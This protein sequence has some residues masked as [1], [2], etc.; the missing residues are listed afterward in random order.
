MLV[1]FSYKLK[2]SRAN[3]IIRNT[4]FWK[5]H[6]ILPNI[7]K[8]NVGDENFDIII[9]HDL[10]VLETGLKLA[11]HFDATIFYDSLEIYTETINQFFPNVTG[12]K[13]NIANIL[14]RFMRWAGTKAEKRMV[15]KCD[16]ITTVN[17]S[18][19][20]YFEDN[21]QLDKVHS[22]MNCP[23]NKKGVIIPLID[24]RKKYNF[25]SNDLIFL[26]QGVLNQGRGLNMLIEGFKLATEQNNNIKLIVLGEG[27]L[28]NALEQQVEQLNLTSSIK[29]TNFVPYNELFNHTI[30]ADF[31]LNFLEPFNLSKKFASP[32]KLFEYIQVGIPVLS[33]FSPENDLIYNKY[34]IGI[35]TENIPSNICEGILKLAS[36]DTNT[37][38]T[39]LSEMQKASEKYNWEHQE[40]ILIGLIH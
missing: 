10:P 13:K 8:S 11:K 24:F 2:Q 6:R 16:I 20:S 21:Y 9:C 40:E 7:I 4:F 33:S 28:R 32:N 18:L 39:Y 38:N 23:S 17:Q 3:K 36:S 29:F 37:M 15:Q 30:A 19:A 27:V 34:E 26:Y 35:Q 12:I 25:S 22:I 5:E 1:F 31:G 14:I